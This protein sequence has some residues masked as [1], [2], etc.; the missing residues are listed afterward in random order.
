MNRRSILT[1]AVAAFAGLF[2]A[3]SSFA[4]H[5]FPEGSPKFETKYK[6]ALAEAKKTGKP[7]IA[8]F[9]A[10]W[11]G[12]CQ[13]NKKNVYPSAEVKPFH[14]KFVWVYLD[15][16]EAGNK[17]AAEEFQ[18]SSIP[19]IQFLNKDG[20]A[21]DKQIGGSTPAGFAKTLEG[22]L[23]KAGPASPSAPEKPAS[24]LQ[25]RKPA[26]AVTEKKAS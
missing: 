21:I 16:D 25:P 4:G 7:I 20:K 8:V 2:V 15:V 26:P 23:A 12:P 13:A 17:K 6:S 1:L 22:V 10:T 11:C 5:D 19:H 18:V 24:G 3:R 14:D 9:S